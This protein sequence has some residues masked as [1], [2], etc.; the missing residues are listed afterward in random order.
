MAPSSAWTLE[1]LRRHLLGAVELELLTIPPYLCALYS[2]HARSNLEAALVIRSVAVEEMLHMVLAANVL[3]AIGGRPDITGGGYVPR[4]PAAIPYHDPQS[5]QVGLRSFGDDALDTFLAIEN[6]SYP[7]ASPLAAPDDAAIPRATELAYDRGYKTIGAFYAAIEE[8]LRTLES[9][10]GPKALFT[11][12]ANLQVSDSHYYASG[13]KVIVVTDLHTALSALE[14]IVDQG[15]GDMRPDAPEEKFDD[16]GDLAHYYRFNELR[17]RR[18]YKPSDMPAEPTGDPIAIDMHAVYEMQPNL[19]V[20]DLPAGKLREQVIACNVIYAGLLHEIQA[21]FSG[22]P[23]RLL[24]ATGTMF[25]LKN[26][27]ND[28]LRIPLPDGS[29]M[30][31]GPTFEYPPEGGAG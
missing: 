14:Q 13:G 2:L 12:N 23:D 28:L 31:A 27:A 30:H 25:D 5:F 22:N 24:R 11:G 18:R 29:G 21:A 16:E 26:A 19:R 1:D 6:P 20:Q 8:G 15:E 3:N 17:L 10:L 4:Y 9:D 7:V